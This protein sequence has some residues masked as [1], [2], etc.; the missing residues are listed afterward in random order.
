MAFGDQ[1]ALLGVLS[2]LTGDDVSQDEKLQAGL[3]LGA[4]V[5]GPSNILGGSPNQGAIGQTGDSF[6]DPLL[7]GTG[8]AIAPGAL[9]GRRGLPTP[10]IAPGRQGQRPRNEPGIDFVNRRQSPRLEDI[11]SLS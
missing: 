4:S 9:G 5:L 6:M 8:P 10:P 11:I 7:F 1:S 3:G 2:A